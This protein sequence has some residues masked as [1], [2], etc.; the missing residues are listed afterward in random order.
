[1]AITTSFSNDT[2]SGGAS[3]LLFYPMSCESQFIHVRQ[4]RPKLESKVEGQVVKGYIRVPSLIKKRYAMLSL[5][6]VD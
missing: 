2:E 1:M 4:N 6:G 3:A 5:A